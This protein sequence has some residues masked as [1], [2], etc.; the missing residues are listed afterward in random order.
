MCFWISGLLTKAVNA[1]KS[2]T[3]SPVWINQPLCAQ[4]KLKIYFMQ[5]RRRQ[6][7]HTCKSASWILY[8]VIFRLDVGQVFS[9][10]SLDGNHFSLDI[11]LPLYAWDKIVTRLLQNQG[12]SNFSPSWCTLSSSERNCKMVLS[13]SKFLLKFWR[14]FVRLRNYS[15]LFLYLISLCYC[16]SYYICVSILLFFFCRAGRT[17]ETVLITYGFSEEDRCCL[18]V[19]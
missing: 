18:T 15:C 13:T 5:K 14:L 1:V 4:H 3:K 17:K 10:V 19:M 9:L 16:N 2:L 11:Y 12:F 7:L 8:Q 6:Q